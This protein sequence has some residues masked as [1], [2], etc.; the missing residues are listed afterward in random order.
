MFLRHFC[1]SGVA[2]TCGIAVVGVRGAGGQGQTGGR[3]C[4]YEADWGAR[5]ARGQGHEVISLSDINV[6]LERENGAMNPRIEYRF[7]YGG[8]GEELVRTVREDRQEQLSSDG[9]LLAEF[10][11]AFVGLL[12]ALLALCLVLFLQLFVDFFF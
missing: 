11:L 1:A 10:P 12:D 4:C 9:A 3:E 7:Q 2:F 6:Q 5:W 8:D